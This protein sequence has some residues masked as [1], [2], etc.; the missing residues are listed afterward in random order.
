MDSHCIQNKTQYPYHDL[1]ITTWSCPWIYLLLY[2]ICFSCC[3]HKFQIQWI[4][5]DIYC[6]TL[7]FSNP[8][9]WNVLPLKVYTVYSFSSFESKLKCQL[10][11]NIFPELILLMALLAMLPSLSISA[12][13]HYFILFITF[14]YWN[15]F[16]GLF[17]CLFFSTR[18]YI[19]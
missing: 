11:R 15:Y 4:S 6:R 9:K 18:I 8:V 16:T 13:L 12:I 2:L 5:L 14:S 19:V 1:Y 7:Q 3:F 10:F 17:E